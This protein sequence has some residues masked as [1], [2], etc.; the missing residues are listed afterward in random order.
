MNFISLWQTVLELCLKGC[1]KLWETLEAR[2]QKK[3]SKLQYWEA[4][5]LPE[6]QR[7]LK[8]FEGLSCL[9]D[10]QGASS[11]LLLFYMFLFCIWFFYNFSVDW[12]L[13]VS[14]LQHFRS[15]QFW[16]NL[17]KVKK[18]KTNWRYLKM[19]LENAVSYSNTLTLHQKWKSL[20]NKVWTKW[21]SN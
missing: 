12:N 10:G 16:K 13:D 4:A 19:H 15:S 18:Y 7:S 3:N 8:I 9:S 20:S 21:T 2:K 5:L 1:N 17:R 14:L 6:W 11:L